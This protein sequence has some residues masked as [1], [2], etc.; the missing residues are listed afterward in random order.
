MSVSMS[1]PQRFLEGAL[2]TG[3]EA[4]LV[5]PDDLFD[6]VTPDILAKHLPIKLKAK[7][8]GACLNASR[9]TPTFM[10]DV[11]GLEAMVAYSPVHLLWKALEICM[12]R[13]LGENTPA[14]GVPRER[15][16]RSTGNFYTGAAAKSAT[17]KVSTLANLKRTAPMAAANEEDT[18]NGSHGVEE[19]KMNE[20]ALGLGGTKRIVGTDAG[21]DMPAENLDFADMTHD[22]SIVTSVGSRGE[23]DGDNTH[24]RNRR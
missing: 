8:L 21:G 15:P 5:R 23:E 3:L 16:A 19:L 11:V 22:D 4:G 18:L 7:L 6:Q 24:P 17:K 20:T 13:A 1:N 12:Q 14:D 10:L 2:A 9:V